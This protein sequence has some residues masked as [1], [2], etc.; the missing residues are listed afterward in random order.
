MEFV[1]RSS[2]G[3]RFTVDFVPLGGV[4]A[5]IV[6]GTPSTFIRKP[7]DN[8]DGLFMVITRQG[9]FA[10]V[11]QGER[12]ELPAGAAAVF[13]NRCAGELHC[14]EEGATWSISLPRDAL[15]HLVSDIESTVER[16]I[17]ATNP[18]LRLLAGY[19]DTLFTL[20]EIDDP[21]LAGIHIADLV[22]GALGPQ[23]NAA[24]LIEGRSVRTV[25][26]RTVLDFIEKNAGD[27]GLTPSGVAEKLGLSVRYLHR[28]LE[29]SGKTFSERVLDRRLDLAHRV[30]RDPRFAHSKISEIAMEAGF[31]DLSHFNRSFRRRFGAT[32]SEVRAAAARPENG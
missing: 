31:P 24:A 18:A 25:R 28:L 30:L 20:E 6:H 16:L 22:A 2:N 26:L 13:D 29:H 9:R 14:D 5:G 1:D 19:L 32:P 17:P 7:V 23:R 3:L 12:H 27:P 10:V 4:A 21:A 11:Q 15:R 8:N